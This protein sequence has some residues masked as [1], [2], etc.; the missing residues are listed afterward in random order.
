VNSTLSIASRVKIVAAFLCLIVFIQGIV[1]YAKNTVLLEQASHT[2]TFL[3]PKLTAAKEAR[4][5]VNDIP[6][7][8]KSIAVAG[9]RTGSSPYYETLQNSAQIVRDNTAKLKTLDPAHAGEYQALLEKFDSFYADSKLVADTYMSQGPARGQPLLERLSQQEASLQSG[10]RTVHDRVSQEMESQANLQTSYTSNTRLLISIGA[11]LTLAITLAIFIYVTSMIS[12]LPNLVANVL[13]Q[14]TDTS[15]LPLAKT[16]EIDKIIG[17]LQETR[18]TITDVVDDVKTTTYRLSEASE[19]LATTSHQGR[20]LVSEQKDQAEMVATTFNE[21][22]ASI[23]DVASNITGTATAAGEAND[24][25]ERGQAVVK[26][27]IGKIEQLAKQIEDTAAIVHH[28]EKDTASIT[29]VLDVIRGVAEQ[30]NLLALNAAI[31]AARAGEQGRGFAVVADEVRTLASRTQA[32]TEEINT[33]IEK[34]LTGSQSAV[35]EMH[36]SQAQAKEVVE[37]A[38]LAG[39]SLSSIAEAVF[40]INDMSGQIATA[41]EEQS[42]VAEEIN[43]SISDMNN[44][45]NE[46]TETIDQTAKASEQLA[47]LSSDLQ[48]YVNKL[49]G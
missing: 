12:Q 49:Q 17:V 46:T 43:R 15:Q 13:R 29:G 28:L 21:M 25:T 5:A 24:E 2:T 30:T 23:Q 19:Q 40:K 8:I 41:A 33:M 38:T 9:T 22:T 26:S 11:A 35:E 27:A 45:F 31:E 36:K 3:L 16:E 37:Q 7:T 32:S 42:T 44:K 48:T 34:L 4:L 1:I 18:N 6:F 39:C 14:G 47:R 20:F 10:F